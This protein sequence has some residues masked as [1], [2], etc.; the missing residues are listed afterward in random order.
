MC[1]SAKRRALVITSIKDRCDDTLCRTVR[2]GGGWRWSNK[3][4]C[5]GG[6]H[7]D[8]SRVWKGRCLMHSGLQHV[9]SGSMGRRRAHIGCESHSDER[10][11]S[12]GRRKSKTIA[13]TCGPGK[14]SR[15]AEGKRREGQCPPQLAACLTFGLA[16]RTSVS[17]SR[18]Q[19][20]CSVEDDEAHRHV[21][22]TLIF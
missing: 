14:K 18:D 13:D 10:G 16:A 12:R 4:L 3:S 2:A 5:L 6:E 9:H 1:K 8:W 7:G 20:D 11:S 15:F 22:V 19:G 21:V 17:M